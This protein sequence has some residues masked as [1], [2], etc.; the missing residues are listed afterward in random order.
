MFRKKLG[1]KLNIIIIAAVLLIAGI[2]AYQG[3]NMDYKVEDGHIKISWFTGVEIPVK[4]I[5]GIK[6]L[7]KAPAIT[8]IT[9]VDLFNVREG[10]Y[11]MDGVGKV[12]LYV[13]D[14]GRK[15]VLV[16]TS[17]MIYGLSPSNP[18]QF[19]KMINIR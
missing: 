14:I 10:V 17:S 18:E 7:D 6:V 19:V 8:K 2:L 13:S 15:I 1:L 9:G 16:K 4:D 12:R 3:M 11:T 5:T